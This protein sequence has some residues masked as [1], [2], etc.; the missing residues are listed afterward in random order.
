MH[1]IHKILCFKEFLHKI[2]LF[3]K[4]LV[5]LEFQSIEPVSRPIKIAIKILVWLCTFW[6][7]LDWFWINWRHF[8][9]IE[10]NF[11]SIESQIEFFFFLNLCFSRVLSLSNYFKKLFS[12]SIWSVQDSQQDFCHFL[13]NFFKGFCLHTLV[14]PF[15]PSFSIYFHYSCI[16]SCI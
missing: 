4:K 8:R 6:S 11:R 9:S 13:Q 16:F 3:F 7:M 1:F 15:Y 2:A 12:L 10:S 5:F 14:R